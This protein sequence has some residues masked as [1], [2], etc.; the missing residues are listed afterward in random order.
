[1]DETKETSNVPQHTYLVTYRIGGERI[2]QCYIAEDTEEAASE[3][4]KQ[5]NEDLEI[6]SIHEKV[7]KIIPD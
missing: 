7:R 1:M 4:M 5:M 2:R 6:L 3:I